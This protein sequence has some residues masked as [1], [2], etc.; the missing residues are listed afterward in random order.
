MR[1]NFIRPVLLIAI[2]FLVKSLVTN[3]CLVL[4]MEPEPAES[5][6]FFAM[7]IAALVVY[8]RIVKK[9]KR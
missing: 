7:I 8:T 4:G 1:Y 6:G 5:L 3:L 9:R 2:A